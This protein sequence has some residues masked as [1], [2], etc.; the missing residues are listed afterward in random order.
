MVSKVKNS[1]RFVLYNKGMKVFFATLSLLLLLFFVT[2]EIHAQSSRPVPWW[3]VQSIDTMKYSRDKA[4]EGLLDPS[5]DKTIDEQ[6]KN[7]A[8]TGA[9]HVAI[10]TP[11]DEEFVPFLKKWVY[12]ARKYG[13]NVWFRGNFS[14]W[15]GW[16]SYPRIT[17]EEHT[18]RIQ[19]FIFRNPDLFE[20]GDIFT[21]CTECEN[22][23]IGDPRKTNDV[24]GFREFLVTEYKTAD[25]AF[26]TIGKDVKANYFSMN[27]DVAKLVMDKDTTRILGGIVVIDHYVA[28]PE[29]LV[30]DIRSLQ[31]S[32]GGN[33]VLGEYG[34]PIPGIHGQM[35]EAEQADWVMKSLAQISQIPFV[36]GINYWVSYGG[37]TRLWEDNNRARLAQGEL[38]KYYKPYLLKGSLENQFGGPV[39]GAI[40]QYGRKRVITNMY[41]QFEIPYVSTSGTIIRAS[42][43]GYTDVEEEVEYG[44]EFIA[45]RTQKLERNFFDKIYLNVYYVWTRIFAR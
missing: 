4:R 43:E 2:G 18:K 14:G 3:Y 39:G 15:E 9:T 1:E 17:Q 13:L 26:I 42:A 33:I 7:I 21:T 41:G 5:F 28:T 19:E 35:N 24:E 23:V 25:D 45:L 20:D 6:M 34:A 31:E 36:I 37:T 27:G 32:S 10:G 44:K 8:Q 22:G 11:Y 40:V 12:S 38:A 29:K 16:F 30:N